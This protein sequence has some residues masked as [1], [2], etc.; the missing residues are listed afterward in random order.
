MHQKLTNIL[1][2]SFLLILFTS[3]SHEISCYQ[4]SRCSK[5]YKLSVFIQNKDSGNIFVILKNNSLRRIG[6]IDSLQLIFYRHNINLRQPIHDSVLASSEK[7]IIGVNYDE[8]IVFYSSQSL[9]SLIIKS[10]KVFE[11]EIPLEFLLNAVSKF[12]NKD[13]K[14]QLKSEFQFFWEG[15]RKGKMIYHLPSSF[16][17]IENKTVIDVDRKIKTE[18]K[19]I[20]N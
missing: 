13:N 1:F 2:I 18:F 7:F 8:P 20:N 10:G 11:T 16:F 15:F 12:G 5:K 4:V 3:C 17:K 19:Q 14:I 6:P 9:N